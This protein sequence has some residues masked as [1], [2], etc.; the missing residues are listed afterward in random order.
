MMS[1]TTSGREAAERALDA[2]GALGAPWWEAQALRALGADPTG[3]EARLGIS[4]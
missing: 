1:A 2:A 4:Q 3:L